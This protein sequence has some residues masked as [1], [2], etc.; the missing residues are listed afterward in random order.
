MLP[1]DCGTH[2]IADIARVQLSA[3]KTFLTT[4][5]DCEIKNVF[6]VMEDKESYDVFE[7]Y[8]KRIF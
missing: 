5:K 8:Y 6:I 7:E 2:D 3:I 1:T 4:E